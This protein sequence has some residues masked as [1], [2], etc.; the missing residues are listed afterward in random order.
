MVARALFLLS[1]HNLNHNQRKPTERCGDVLSDQDVTCGQHQGG[2]GFPAILDAATVLEDRPDWRDR[3]RAKRLGR[4]GRLPL[5]AM[6]GTIVSHLVYNYVL[7]PGAMLIVPVLLLGLV[8]LVGSM[9][10]AYSWISHT[11]A[12]IE[13]GFFPAIY[14]GLRETLIDGALTMAITGG[15]LFAL[16]IFLAFYF[17]SHQSKKQFEELYILLARANDRLKQ[18]EREKAR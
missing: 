17:Q 18:L 3:Q 8:I 15:S 12:M 13:R 6:S 11:A 7:R 14:G 16:L 1:T 2:T 10:L 9:T 4:G 5:L